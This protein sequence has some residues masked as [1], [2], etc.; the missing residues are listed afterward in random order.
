MQAMLAEN[1]RVVR[2]AGVRIALGSDRYRA[3]SGAEVRALRAT[4]LFADTTLLR[5]WSMDTPRAIY[6][7]RRI[8]SLAAGAEASF[9]VLGANP[10]QDW[11]VL[12]R[13][14]MRLKDGRLLP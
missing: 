10:L 8:G 3:S 5:L 12:D 9:L 1:L 13:I 7:A 4:G 14:R 11:S 6:P 2:D